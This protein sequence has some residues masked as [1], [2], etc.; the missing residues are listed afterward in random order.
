MIETPLRIHIRWA[1]G[2]VDRIPSLPC[3]DY[4]RDAISAR[5]KAA[6]VA[7]KANVKKLGNYR[8]IAEAKQR[9]TTGRAEAVIAE[10][11]HPRRALLP[12]R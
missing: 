10:T 2:N 8:R 5:T 11:A 4:E 7:A 12:R 1:R 6:L 3:A 9:T